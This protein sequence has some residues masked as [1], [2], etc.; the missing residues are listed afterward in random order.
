MCDVARLIFVDL[1]GVAV[2][3]EGLPILPG[4]FVVAEIEG[5]TWHDAL[6]VPRGAFI[7]DVVYVIEDGR[8][9]VRTPRVIGFVG[10]YALIEDGLQPGARVILTNLEVLFDGLPV[11][12]REN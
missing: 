2:S 4:S 6:A 7:D 8:A 12:G 1:T 11:V 5:R 9:S 10:G 3:E